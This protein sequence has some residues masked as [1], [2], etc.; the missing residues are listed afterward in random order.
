M[1]L[2]FR[3]AESGD[4]P[5]VLALWKEADAE[6]SSTDDVE[7]LER[8]R[9]HDPEALVLAV[10]DGRIVGS[11]VAGWDGWRGTV[12]RLVVAADYRRHGLAGRLVEMAERRLS[13]LGAAR[14]QATVVAGSP[15][16]IGF[17]RAG[18]WSENTGQL[19][20]TKTAKS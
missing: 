5:A 15:L 7:S 2:T 19:R 6:P 8:L 3:F 11:I 13:D 14:L 16:A 18:S 10:A 1:E 4:L 17:W 9:S 12:H 20:F